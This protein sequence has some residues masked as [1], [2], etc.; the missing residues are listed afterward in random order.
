MARKPDGERRVYVLPPELL[1]RVRSY[2][3]QMGI[4]SEV[5]AVRR[6]L[7]EALQRRDDVD[8]ILNKMVTRSR[9]EKDVRMLAKEILSS[10][11]LVTEI[12]YTREGVVF[13]LE[14][15]TTGLMTYK[16]EPKEAAPDGTFQD[17]IPF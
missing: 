3:G 10:H 5:E 4:A 13:T 8:S 17:W 14:G 9:S 12:R 11:P 15:G 6:L 2:Q 1:Q 16:L 7:D